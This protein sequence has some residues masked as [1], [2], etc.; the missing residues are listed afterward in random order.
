MP[1]ITQK[2]N[3]LSQVQSAMTE[4]TNLNDRV[5]TLAKLFADRNYDAAANDP[6]TI[7]DLNNLG[8]IVYDVGVAVNIF[9]ALNALCDGKA[10]SDN[11]A[12]PATFSKWRV[13]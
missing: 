11:Q 12:I 10:V 1:T 7:F 4:P 6:V 2:T 8:V 5:R 13:I 3:Y 9:Q